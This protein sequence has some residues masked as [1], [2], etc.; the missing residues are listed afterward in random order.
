[1]TVT[2]CPSYYMSGFSGPNLAERSFEEVKRISINASRDVIGHSFDRERMNKIVRDIYRLGVEW[3]AD[4]IAQTEREEIRIADKGGVNV[5]EPLIKFGEFLK[6]VVPEQAA[7]SWA[8]KHARVFFDVEDW[9]K[10]MK[11]Y[12]FVL[13]NRFHGC[14]VALQ[15]DVPAVVICHDTRTE[16][17][18]QFLAMPFVSIVDLDGI[19]VEFLYSL[20]DRAALSG[21]N[22]ASCIHIM[23]SF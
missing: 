1:M 5:D 12:D 22:T 21:D 9:L 23:K 11:G 3:N 8:A 15:C 16:D 7:R 18:C 2:G 19:D 13:G 6:G 14:M 10:A 20:I 4:F 17:M